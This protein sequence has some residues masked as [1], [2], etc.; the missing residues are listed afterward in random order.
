MFEGALSLFC[1]PSMEKWIVVRWSARSCPASIQSTLQENVAKV[2][3]VRDQPCILNLKT[4]F[5]SIGHCVFNGVY[6]DH[7]E[8]VTIKKCIDCECRDGSMQCFKIDPVT[9]CPALTCP[10]EEQFSVAD[11][12]CK[13]CPGRYIYIFSQYEYNHQLLITT[14][15]SN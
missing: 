10:L 8:Q 13:F 4:I 1:F 2:V 6:Y 7:G 14:H 11:N 15:V 9:M 5:V 3:S 12:C